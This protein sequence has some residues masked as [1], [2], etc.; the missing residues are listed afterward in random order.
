MAE[1]NATSLSRRA[2]LKGLP[3]AAA[4]ICAVLPAMSET[5]PIF[6]AIKKH[7]EAYAAWSI[8]CDAHDDIGSTEAEK[9]AHQATI[10][11]G[12]V[13]YDQLIETP[14]T[15]VAGLLTVIAWLA[16]FDEGCVPDTCGAWLEA[17]AKSEAFS[18]LKVAGGFDV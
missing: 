5:D 3:V 1:Q 2:I 13:A 8:S 15:T 16:E 14:A 11:A 6:A 17:F 18:N 12:R 4:A 7:R 10:Q 9:A